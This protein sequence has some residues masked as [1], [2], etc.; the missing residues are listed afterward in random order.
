MTRKRW[1]LVAVIVLTLGVL[2][3]GTA[4]Y[5][6]RWSHDTLLARAEVALRADQIDKALDYTGQ[7]IDRY[8]DDWE[9]YFERARVLLAAGRYEDARKQL[10]KARA[11]DGDPE[12]IGLLQARS[13]SRAGRMQL[14]SAGDPNAAELR[15]ALSDFTH[16]RESL[17]GFAGEGES[18]SPAV[19]E[20]QGDCLFDL[21]KANQ[22][23]AVELREQASVAR[24]ARGDT[25]AATLEEQADRAARRAEKFFTQGRDVL[26]ALVKE[27]PS[28]SSAAELLVD[29]CIAAGDR[30]TLSRLDTL[31]NHSGHP[32][33]RAEVNL[34]TF[35]VTELSPTDP[36]D[37]KKLAVAAERMEAILADRP[38]MRPARLLLARV[39]IRLDDAETARKHNQ[40]LLAANPEDRE[41]RLIEAQLLR[42]DGD[43]ARAERKLFSLKT[44]YP[45]WLAAHMM[46]ALAAS[47]AGY[48]DLARQALRQATRIAPEYPE[49]RRRLAMYLLA[50]GFYEEA[51]GEARAYHRV[52]PDQPQAVRLYAVTAARAGFED[53]AREHL[54]DAK[55]R[56]ADRPDMLVTIAEAYGEIGAGASAR[57]LAKEVANTKPD[58]AAARLAVARALML[59]GRLEEA[60]E[61]LETQRREDPSQPEVLLQLARIHTARGRILDALELYRQAVD[62]A[63][64]RPRYAIELARALMDQGE[65]EE[66]SR[67][68]DAL[69]ADH[70]QASLLR[71]QVQLR[72][73]LPM[74]ADHLVRQVEEGRRRGLPLA[75]IHL[76]NGLPH[77]CVEICR[78][79]LQKHPEDIGTL[80]LLGQAYLAMDQTDACVEQWKK[81]VE[82]SPERLAIYLQLGEVLARSKE[83]DQVARE[84]SAIPGAME[85][86]VHMTAGALFAGNNEPSRAAARFARVVEDESAGE[87]L[88]GRA[89][90]LRVRALAQADQLDRAVRQLDEIEAMSVW[91]TQ[92]ILARA[93]LMYAARQRNAGAEQ[94]QRALK[95]AGD[96]KD[97]AA[98]RRLLRVAMGVR[99]TGVAL[100][101]AEQAARLAPDEPRSHMDMARVHL[102][103]RRPADAEAA[104]RAAVAAEPGNIRAQLMLVE[105]LDLQGKRIEALET[106]EAMEK[107]GRANQ[108]VSL[109]QQ[110]SLLRRWGLVAP[111][112]ERYV[113]LQEL[114]YG[115]SPRV[116]LALGVTY[117]RLGDRDK[118][119]ETLEGIAQ[120]ADE[121]VRARLVIAE[122]A[123]T[124]EEKLAALKELA[125]KNPDQP[126]IAMHQMGVLLRSNR[127][128]EAAA[129]FRTLLDDP[130]QGSLSTSAA[131]EAVR[132]MV[133]EGRFA[134]AADTCMKLMKRSRQ[135]GWR[136]LAILLT[137]ADKPQVASQMLQQV[138][139]P[140]EMDMLLAIAKAGLDGDSETARAW[141]TRLKA[142]RPENNR[143]V[144]RVVLLAALV[145]DPNDGFQMAGEHKPLASHWNWA[146]GELAGAVRDGSAKPA[147][148]ARLLRAEIARVLAVPEASRHWALE[149]LKARPTCRWPVALELD[150]AE[151]V[152]PR[153]EIAETF[154]PKDA[155]V[156]RLLQASRLTWER[157]FD[158]ALKLYARLAEAHPQRQDVRML[159]ASTA[160]AAGKLDEALTLYQKVYEE[161]KH[162]MAA[163]NAAYLIAVRQGDDEKKLRR[164]SELAEAALRRFPGSA[165]CHDTTGWL[166]YLRKD[167]ARAIRHLLQAVRRAPQTPEIHY[168]LGMAE[169]SGGSETLGEWHLRAAVDV[170]NRLRKAEMPLSSETLRVLALAEKSLK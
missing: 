150:F 13:W 66:T 93:R 75:L 108:S 154:Q 147:E 82:L 40:A 81:V 25:R 159:H 134:Q 141:W 60:R 74:E 161:F 124:P 115:K 137:M 101:A 143:S 47:E 123:E 27:D 87:Y 32:A 126:A 64:K 83:I 91:Q 98:L 44:R 120:H 36:A 99:E 140:D 38:K 48:P 117:F 88:R 109:L 50:E 100:Q 4:W 77:K 90:L 61:L 21:A 84:L 102:A 46:Y 152:E 35:R 59:T 149:V 148:T 167:Y 51:Y 18:P 153:R 135:P 3:G 97:V 103:S 41:A 31:L 112:M 71:L 78:M 111:A 20:M 22:Q 30:S 58:S 76:R 34:W 144:N 104:C 8:P 142:T 158:Q 62:A 136:Y 89:G 19:R 163:N 169:R 45:R 79:E 122:M 49:A 55:K 94:L 23:L 157:K 133:R 170:G 29:L 139:S 113:R 11:R 164:A 132:A 7:Y 96:A 54:E 39:A 67:V 107:Q 125:E 69:P 72:R 68:L 80:S 28:R 118:A 2:A 110:G 138:E 17:D 106:L 129:A 12:R 5:I 121:Y 145:G 70:S 92:A 16:A 53:R 128:E 33:A 37:R 116:Q 105:I 10:D 63:P 119:R 151:R 1:T 43:L 162:P 26:L 166:A 160:E 9:G 6:S 168:H 73:G 131:I 56:F 156:G 95:L 42:L 14:Q 24:A 86:L 85:N 52:A 114:G 165:A 155:P 127:N 57:R 130:E 146:A 15:T 65:L